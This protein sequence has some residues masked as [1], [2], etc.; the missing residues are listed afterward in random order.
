MPPEDEWVPIQYRDFYDVPRLFT[1][2]RGRVT[3]L[4]ECRFNEDAD[5]YEDHYDVYVLPEAFQA[6]SGSWEA[7]SRGL[8]L[9]AR[10][11]VNG[12]RFDAS[13]RRTVR[14]ELVEHFAKLS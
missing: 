5:N 6:P 9:L 8:V 1:A 2:S 12:V 13:R 4:F 10:V 14:R 11:P 7:V 3:L